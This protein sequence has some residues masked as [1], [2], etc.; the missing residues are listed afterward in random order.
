MLHDCEHKWLRIVF[1]IWTYLSYRGHA[2]AD[3]VRELRKLG[4]HIYRRA[5]VP[6]LDMHRQRLLFGLLCIQDIH[7]V[8]QH[9]RDGQLRPGNIHINLRFHIGLHLCINIRVH[10][11]E[12]I[13]ALFR[14]RQH[15][16]SHINH[17]HNHY[18]PHDHQSH[19]RAAKL[20]IMRQHN[21]G[22]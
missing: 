3:H 14:I 9:N 20:S 2:A 5:D 4:N 11:C 1:G 21:L 10:V 8:K 16:C 22:Y 6:G 15:H 13:S 18:Q 7:P 17:Y 12:H 19:Y